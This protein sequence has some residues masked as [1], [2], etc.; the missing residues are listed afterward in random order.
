MANFLARWILQISFTTQST[1]MAKFFVEYISWAYL[2][3]D[4]GSY[5]K[6]ILHADRHVS[7]VHWVLKPFYWQKRLHESKVLIV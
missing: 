2:I 1:T 3:F 5:D 7:I 4:F 6:L